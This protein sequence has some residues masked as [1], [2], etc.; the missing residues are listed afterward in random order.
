MAHTKQTQKKKQNFKKNKKIGRRRVGKKGF[1]EDW[2]WVR[3][4]DRQV[5]SGQN[6]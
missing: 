5:K 2:K 6:E 4:G 1:T 3:E